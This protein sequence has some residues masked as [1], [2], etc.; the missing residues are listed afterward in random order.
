MLHIVYH[1]TLLF[2]FHAVMNKIKMSQDVNANKEIIERDLGDIRK[3]NLSNKNRIESLEIGQDNLTMAVRNLSKTVTD[4]RQAVAP[5]YDASSPNRDLNRESKS[6][7]N[8]DSN[9]EPNS[10]N[11][12]SSSSNRVSNNESGSSNRRLT[13]VSGS[14]VREPNNEPGSPSRESNRKS[15]SSNGES[16]GE[17]S[18]SMRE[19]NIS[20]SSSTN[21]ELNRESSSSKR[22]TNREFSSS[23]GEPN[24]EP[25]S[26]NNVSNGESSSPNRESNIESSSTNNHN[27]GTSTR[28]RDTYRT[29]SVLLIHD[30]HF[31]AFDKKLFNKQFNVHLFQANS[32]SALIQ[33]SKQLYAAIKRIRPECIYI[34]TGINDF[35]KKKSG[36]VNYI[37]DL[38]ELLLKESDAQ[39]GFSLLIPTNDSRLNTKIKVVN[40]DIRNYVTW[41]LSISPRANGRL[42][43]FSNNSLAKENSHDPN[44]GFKLSARGQKLLWLHLRDGLK[45]TLRLPRAQNKETRNGQPRTNRF[46]C[47]F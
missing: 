29:H 37:E 12:E 34:H 21:R 27:S 18:S 25:N 23:N 39:I 45:K 44:T 24:R 36:L 22:E 11:R 1:M 41:L 42:F 33:K 47:R 26:S 15:S 32:Y 10:S 4:S 3:V 7:L 5:L 14:S 20:E 17:P 46:N 28:Q 16:N 9:R 40:D 30:E 38:A 35:I 13:R 2:S 19:P 6:F 43:T 8:R 31:N